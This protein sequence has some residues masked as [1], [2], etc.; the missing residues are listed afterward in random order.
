VKDA[1]VKDAAVKDAAVKDAAVNS[2]PSADAKSEA[3]KA[4]TFA[5]PPKADTAS[6]GAS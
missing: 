4:A 1:A 3:E 2:D 5:E 6:K